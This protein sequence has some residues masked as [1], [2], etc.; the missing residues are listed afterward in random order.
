M[1]TAFDAVLLAGGRG[2]RLGGVRKPT[3]TV[4]GRRLVDIALAAAA[5]AR[6]RVVVGD[7]EV[8]SG[9]L[10]TREYPPYG[11]PVAALAAGLAVL[12]PPAEWTLVLATDLPGAEAAVA[13][14]L[15]AT[16]AAEVDGVCLRD[17]DGRLQWLLGCYR[18]DALR[19]RLADRGDPPLT[20]MWRLLEPLRLAG[21]DPAGAA[22]DD[23]DTLADADRWGATLPDQLA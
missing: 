16:P 10:R 1:I 5:R 12:D 6:R 21:V 19:S 17:H 7:V 9:V 4:D 3:L 13:R 2:S 8:P 14:L 20:A 11:G 18:T 22:L 23:I 15:A